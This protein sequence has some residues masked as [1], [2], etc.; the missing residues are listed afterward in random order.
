MSNYILEGFLQQFRPFKYSSPVVQS[1][2]SRQPFGH[3]LCRM[4]SAMT[5]APATL[6]GA[7]VE[8]AL[9]SVHVSTAQHYSVVHLT[10]IPTFVEYNNEPL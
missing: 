4:Q 1:T 10:K 9:I 3:N 5:P 2:D 6:R 7:K 8:G